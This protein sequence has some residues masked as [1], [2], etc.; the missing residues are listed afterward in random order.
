MLSNGTHGKRNEI[1]VGGNTR[2]YFAGKILTER[3]PMS[4]PTKLISWVP[5]PEGRECDSGNPRRGLE[6]GL[7]DTVNWHDRISGTFVEQREFF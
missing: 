2:A 3:C 5:E 6:L 1:A 4:V 7:Q